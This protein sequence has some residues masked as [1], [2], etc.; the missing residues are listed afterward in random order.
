MNKLLKLAVV[1][2]MA[3]GFVTTTASADPAKGQ[4]LYLKKYKKACGVTGGA[5]AAKHTQAEW[6]AIKES[7]K[8]SEELRTLCP[9]I[10]KDIPEK[11]QDDMFDF[12]HNYA[13]DSGNVP[14]C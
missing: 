1:A 5:I 10:T 3:V 12:F 8:F 6:K 13:S 7:G 4:K 11:Y 2:V 9:E 14:A